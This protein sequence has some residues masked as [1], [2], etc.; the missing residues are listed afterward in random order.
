[1]KT[2]EVSGFPHHQ[3]FQTLI[4]QLIESLIPLDNDLSLVLAQC[5]AYILRLDPQIVHGSRAMD[6]AFHF[7]LNG[8][9]IPTVRHDLVFTLETWVLKKLWTEAFNHGMGTWGDRALEWLS[10]AVEMVN[11]ASGR[12]KDDALV[13]VIFRRGTRGL[14]G[15]VSLS[16]LNGFM[17]WWVGDLPKG[18]VQAVF[19]S[20]AGILLRED[21]VTVLEVWPC[22]FWRW[23]TIDWTEV[24]EFVDIEGVRSDF[25]MVWTFMRGGSH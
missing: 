1:L 14:M 19:P 12:T 13:I 8:P 6:L 3:D 18:I 15:Q 23:L 10:Q 25:T 20:L 17:V 22:I 5:L 2:E 4:L 7:F 24:V 16:V 21:D 9:A 11:I